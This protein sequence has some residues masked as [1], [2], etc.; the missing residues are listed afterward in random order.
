MMQ[1]MYDNTFCTISHFL[2]IIHVP[3]FISD[4]YLLCNWA[5]I[6]NNSISYI[7]VRLINNILMERDGKIIYY[8]TLYRGS[9][10]YA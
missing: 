9:T 7:K 5:V 6:Q 3:S 8:N 2:I 10:I 4:F 1:L